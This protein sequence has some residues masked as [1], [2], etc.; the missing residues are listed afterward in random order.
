VSPT[1]ILDLE[2]ELPPKRKRSRTRLIFGWA[3]YALVVMAISIGWAVGSDLGWFDSLP[4]SPASN[5]WLLLP[6][7]Y[8][9]ILIHELGHLAVGK[10]AGMNPG[11]LCVGGMLLAKSGDHWVFQFHR[12]YLFGGFAAPLP[13]KNDF[14]RARHAWMVAGGPLASI[15]LTIVC[16]LAIRAFGTGVWDWIGTMFL[17]SVI[18]VASSVIPYKVS[19][20]MS[21]GARLWQLLTNPDRARRWMA[22]VAL[23]AENMKGVRPRDW[24]A[25]VV[26]QALET[27]ESEPSYAV[28]QMLA[29]YRSNDQGDQ[30]AALQRLENALAG[31]SRNG[32]KMILRACFLDAGGMSAKQRHNPAQAR[33]WMERAAALK[34]RSTPGDTAGLEARIAMA[35]GRYAE[36][37]DHWAR[38]RD[39]IEKKRLDSGVIRF[40][41][42][43]MVEAE[44]ECRVALASSVPSVP[45]SAR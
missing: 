13:A 11:A 34:A 1:P 21:D 28:V 8:L 26:Q 35:E 12:K 24:N 45:T 18:T 25:E 33:V 36:A 15:L 44:G 41:K 16:G 4:D 5:G 38:Y 42:D 29:G 14:Q 23:Q 37:L 2:Q 17:S 3:I 7:L 9:A 6:A 10:L 43:L 22:V 30:D 32:N 40:A 27:V 19:G 31:A 20:T 39:L